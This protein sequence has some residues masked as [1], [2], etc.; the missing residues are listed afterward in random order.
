MTEEEAKR[1]FKKY[2]SRKPSKALKEYVHDN[3]LNGYHYIFQHKVGNNRY[4]YCTHCKR[5]IQVEGLRRTIKAEELEL[6]QAKH[7]SAVTCPKCRSRGIKRYAGYNHHDYVV[8]A[9]EYE[10]TGGGALLCF[11]YGFRYNYDDFKNPKVEFWLNNFAYFDIHKYFHMLYGWSGFFPYLKDNY[12]NSYSFTT[13][14]ILNHTPTGHDN[15]PNYAF[16]FYEAINKSNLK[17]CCVEELIGEKIGDVWGY[18]KKYCSYPELFEKLVKEGFHS[19]VVD[20]VYKI[21]LGNVNYR[22][23]STAA[24]F[25]CNRRELNFYKAA[26]VLG[27]YCNKD[28]L[29]AIK[30]IKKY[31]LELNEDNYKFL[32]TRMDFSDCFELMLEFVGFKKMRTYIEKQDALYPYCFM[33]NDY[34]DYV[35]NCKELSWDLTQRS[36]VFPK[37]LY[38]AHQRQIEELKKTRD[39][40]EK[41]KWEKLTAEFVEKRL[42]KLVEKY[43]YSNGEFLIRPAESAEELMKESGVLSHCVYR[44]YTENYLKGRTIIL[45]IRKCSEPDVPYFTLEFKNNMIIQCRTKCNQGPSKEILAFEKEWQNNIKIKKKREVA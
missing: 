27:G 38:I 18:L 3:L 32:Q 45:F 15:N 28:N 6:L 10:V 42:S 14:S 31:N 7:N 20:I 1:I 24:F 4:C 16:K 36:V 5:N 44:N 35:K 22:A 13:A 43:S 2:E 21:S 30:F 9:A 25:G 26:K 33:L 8:S 34:R 17:Y 40:E 29:N 37:N 11:V 12:T 19:E 23:K 39:A 41:K